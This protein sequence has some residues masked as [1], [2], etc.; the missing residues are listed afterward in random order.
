MA[1]GKELE[2]TIIITVA[3]QKG[4]VGK[5][6]I[7]ALLATSFHH[8][9]DVSVCII[10]C[11]H[12]QTLLRMR[13]RDLK[14]VALLRQEYEEAK[15]EGIAV[16]DLPEGIDAPVYPVIKAELDKLV[17]MLK[18][19]S[20]QYDVIFLDV[21]GL[22][23]FGGELSEATKTILKQIYLSTDMLLIPLT[24]SR[25]DIDSTQQF[26]D[27]SNEVVKL[28]RAHGLDMKLY[29]VVNRANRTIENKYLADVAETEGLHLFDTRI[30]DLTRYKRDV[31]TILPIYTSEEDEVYR[32]ASELYNEIEKTLSVEDEE[33]R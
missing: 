1:E 7:T 9:S 17:D 3:N 27:Y 21:P 5:S 22:L 32:L 14:Y 10:D 28:K 25:L 19:V 31:S 29:A 23:D 12:Q 16:E 33:A 4:G 26:V 13:E 11:D 24:P 15:Q 2:E 6:T 8:L 30:R 20:A 18:E